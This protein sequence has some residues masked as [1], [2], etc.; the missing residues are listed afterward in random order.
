VQ[1]PL[2]GDPIAVALFGLM[3]EFPAKSE[4]YRWEGNCKGLQRELDRHADDGVKRSRAWPKTP[5]GL[6]DRLRRL[7]SF[8][9]EEG[10]EVVFHPRG[11]KGQRILSIVKSDVD[12]TVTSV[13]TATESVKRTF[14]QSLSEDTSGDAFPLR[15]AVAP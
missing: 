11:T 10:I 6:S 7:K 14:G 1:E 4:P 13:T 12:L 5:K 8:L 9:R 3:E 15:V 2:E